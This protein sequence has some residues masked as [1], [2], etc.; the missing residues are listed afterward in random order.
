MVGIWFGV[1]PVFIITSILSAMFDMTFVIIQR[2]N[3]QRIVKLI[4]VC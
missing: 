2:Y 3:R 1:Y 4:K